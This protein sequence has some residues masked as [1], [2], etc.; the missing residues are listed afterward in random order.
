LANKPP[1]IEKRR[2]AH[3]VTPFLAGNFISVT[4][5]MVSK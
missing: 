1:T 2:C 3:E 5:L 4:P